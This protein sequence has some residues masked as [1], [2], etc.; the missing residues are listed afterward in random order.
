LQCRSGQKAESLGLSTK[1]LLCISKQI[2]GSSHAR[3]ADVKRRAY[4]PAPKLTSDAGRPTV[5]PWYV[6]RGKRT[7]S[8]LLSIARNSALDE[9]HPPRQRPKT[10]TDGRL[11]RRAAL[12][13]GLGAAGAAHAGPLA[14]APLKVALLGQCVIKFVAWVERS[15]TCYLILWTRRVV[16]GHPAAT[17]SMAPASVHRLMR[18]CVIIEAVLLPVRQRTKPKIR[19]VMATRIRASGFA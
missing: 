4:F 8:Q 2:L 15:H 5:S 17:I 3:A 9:L 18:E 14:S 12:M 13:L 11:S 16:H 7:D 19:P 6:G 10:M 1:R